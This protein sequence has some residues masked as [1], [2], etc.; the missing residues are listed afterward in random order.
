MD[1]FVTF[2][3][4][5]LSN[6]HLVLA[7]CLVYAEGVDSSVISSYLWWSTVIKTPSSS[8][9][10]KKET[11]NNAV[12]ILGGKVFE[13]SELYGDLDLSCANALDGV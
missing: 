7:F 4:F 3:G 2:G 10:R 12:P 5:L 11:A 9:M 1:R 6:P 13:A 8:L